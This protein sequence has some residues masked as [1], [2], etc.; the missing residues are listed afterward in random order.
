V[1][2]FTGLSVWSIERTSAGWLA[3][4]AACPAPLGS[5]IG[6]ICGTNLTIYLSTDRGASWAPISNAGGV[7]SANGRTTLA[8]AKPGEVRGVRVFEQRR[9]DRAQGHL[10]FRRRR[11]DLGGE[12]RQRRARSRPTGPGR[13]AGMNICGG[14]CWYNQSIAV[15]PNDPS[16]NTVW[17]GGN[18]AT[19]STSDGGTTWTLR[20]WWLYSQ[21]PALEYAHA[22]HHMLAFKTTG[23]PSIVL[24]D[25]GGLNVSEDNGATFSSGKNSAWSRTCTTRWPATRSSRTS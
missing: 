11:P 18:L 25:D 5:R 1:P 24:G 21:V 3:I 4:R 23:A 6:V 14:Q 8:V 22:D 19:A 20:T 15:D 2:T 12:R 16:R 17:I 13:P 10:S 9:R 7:F